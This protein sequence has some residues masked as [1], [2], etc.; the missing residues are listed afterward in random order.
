MSLLYLL[1]TVL[2]VLCKFS[3]STPSF[4]NLLV[5]YYSSRFLFE[6][7][8]G[9]ILYTG[10]FRIAKGDCRKF[11]AFM[12]HPSFS[13]YGLKTIDH[14]Y[15]DCTFCSEAARAFPSRE[16]SVE[17][18]TNLIKEWLSRGTDYKV[19]FSLAG[20]GFGAEYVFVEVSKKLKLKVHVSSFKLNIYKDLSRE[21]HDAVTNDSTACLHACT[22]DILTDCVSCKN[23]FKLSIL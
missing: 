6:G 15:V 19:L 16:E 21:I 7:G 12:T 18:T 10:D 9:T 23:T 22:S 17:A 2:V 11:K 8:F 3:I 1:A 5:T 13:D 14:I 20:R 4:Y